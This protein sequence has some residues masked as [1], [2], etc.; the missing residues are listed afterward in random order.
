MGEKVKFAGWCAILL[1]IVWVLAPTATQRIEDDAIEIRYMAPEGPIRDAMEAAVREFEHLTRE[2][3]RIDPS[4]PVIRVVA[5]QHASRDQVEDPTRFLLSLA[6]GDPPDVIFFDRFAISEWAARGAFTPLDPFLAHDQE[7]WTQWKASGADPLHAPWPGALPEPPR[8]EGAPALAGVSPIQAADFYPGAWDEVNYRNPLTRQT[9]LFGIPNNA[10]NR[11]LLY[12]KDM[13]VRYGFT[14][15]L[16]HA[17]PPRSWEEL[18]EMAVAMTETDER[19]NLRQVGFIPNYGNTFL[20]MYGW[21]AGGEFMSEDGLTATLNHPRVVEALDYVTRVYNRLGGAQQVDAFQS[22]FQRDALDPFITGKVAMKIDGVWIMSSLARYGRDLNVGAAP[23]PLPQRELDAGRHPISWLGGWAYAIPSSAQN[24]EAAWE[25]IRFLVS[26][27]ALEI[28]MTSERYTYMAQGRPFVP[29]QIPNRPQNEWMYQTYIAD[30]PDIEPKFRAVMQVYNDMLEHSLCRPVTPVGQQLWNAQRWAMEEAIYGRR[31][32]RDAL[33]HHN[34]IVQ[35]SLDQ[36]LQP[37]PGRPITSWTWFFVLYA[38][39]IS[40]TVV[41]VYRSDTRQRK[42]TPRKFSFFRLVTG[43]REDKQ[44]A[45]IEGKKGSYFRSQWKEGVLCALPWIL[46]FI[47]FTGGPLLFS[48]L[49]SFTRYDIL[50]PAILLGLDNYVAMFTSDEL[51]FKSLWNTLFMIIGIPLGMAIGLGMAILLTQKVRGVAIWRTFFYLPSIV[52]M[53]AASILWIWIFNPQ[54]GLLNGFL[55]YLGITGPL[56]LQD[57]NTSKWA[58]ILMGLWTAGGGMIIWIAG[59]K[60]ISETYYE[61][62]AIDGA[63]KWKQFLYITLP[64]LTPYIFFNLVMGLIGTFQIFTQAFIMTGG[65]PVNSTLFYAYH[66]FNH[67]FRYLN[68]GYAAA[69]AWFLFL[70]VLLLTA[71]QMRMSKRWVHYEDEA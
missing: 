25:L 26:Q 63:G 7:L 5:G 27:R 71:F 65:G 6:G 66:L 58:L 50:N 40:A 67:A 59:L 2:R 31:T 60:G 69:M 23:P 24:Q 46:G 15:E 49:I 16:G 51:F 64:M 44:A 55:A 39:L 43:E 35:R 57:Q 37:P 11:V 42:S 56:W 18:E 12:N 36:T 32:P 52:P 3:N 13:L 33:D 54:S 68:M 9:Q 1:T 41:W 8:A 21:M 61:A 48:I 20:Y 47:L 38:A 45:V 62:A 70:I 14:N 4:Y 19:G 53:V 22:T 28:M 10:D 30:N 29:R 17:R 34:A